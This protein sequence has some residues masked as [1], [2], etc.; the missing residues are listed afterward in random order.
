MAHWRSMIDSDWLR[1][2]DLNGKD[3]TLQIERVTQGQVTQK[4][5]KKKRKPVLYFRGAKKPLAP[6]NTDCETLEKLYGGEVNGWPGKWVT[7][8]TSTTTVGK[9]HNRPCIRI[10]P[11]VPRQGVAAGDK[12]YVAPACDEPDDAGDGGAVLEEDPDAPVSDTSGDAT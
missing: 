9:E 12:P 11:V 2:F 8:F 3:Y 10:R 7:L 5:G 1:A 6:C 4:G